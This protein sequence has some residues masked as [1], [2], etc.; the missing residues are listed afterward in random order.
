MSLRYCSSLTLFGS[1][2]FLLV[3]FSNIT[4][5]FSSLLATHIVSAAEVTT[6]LMTV[7]YIFFF[8]YLFIHFVP[9]VR[10]TFSLNQLFYFAISV[11]PVVYYHSQILKISSKLHFLISIFQVAPPL[12]LLLTSYILSSLN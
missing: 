8:L 2:I 6:V 12:L 7:L 11:I 5:L 1:Y 9:V 4:I 10:Y 3:H